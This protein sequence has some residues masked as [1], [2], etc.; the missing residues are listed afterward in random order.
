MACTTGAEEDA[1]VSCRF[2]S[3]LQAAN[4]KKAAPIAKNLY[5]DN[6]FLP[7][8]IKFYIKKIL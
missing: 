4:V 7:R 2:S 6:M 5:L 3:S 8:I 1:A